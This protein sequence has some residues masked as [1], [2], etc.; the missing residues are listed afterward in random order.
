MFFGSILKEYSRYSEAADALRERKV[1]ISINGISESAQSGLIYAFTED[2]N[3]NS[4]VITYSDLEAQALYAD[5][6]FYTDNVLYFPSKE[7]VFYDI[8][9]AGHQNEYNRLETIFELSIRKEKCIVVASLEAVT[10][11]TVAK[12]VYDDNIINVELGKRFD[13]TELEKK[14]VKLGYIRE[15]MIEGKGQFSVRGGILDIYC[16]HS[17]SPIRIEFFDDETDSIREFDVLTQRSMDTV[18]SA[19]ITPCKELIFDENKRAELSEYL[20]GA[21]L[22]L[23]KKK[24][25]Y[26]D[27]IKTILS[28]KEKLDEHMHFP[29]IDKYVDFIYGQIPTIIDYFNKDSLV[30][31]LEPKR[32]HERKEG[33]EW[34]RGEL[35][36]DFTQSGILYTDEAKFWADYGTILKKIKE[37]KVIAL[38]ELA[39]SD[40]DF[41]YKLL[42]DFVT[43]TTVSFH[44]KIEYLYDDLKHWQDSGATVAILASNRARGENL[45]GILNDKGI[46]CRY[47]NGRA[48]LK[49]GE[50][51]VVK[52]NLKK[53]FEYPD[54]KLAVVSDREIFAVEKRKKVSKKNENVD[55]IKSFNDI[56]VG[57]YVVHR[58]H[59]I[60]QYVGINKM[61]VNGIIKDYFKIQY[62]GSDT[63]YVPVDQM[64]LLYKYIG[65]TDIQIKVHKLGG[66]EWSKTKARVKKSTAQLAGQL[67]KLY[68]VRE[69]TKGYAFSE[70]TAWQREFEDTFVYQETDDQLRSIE[71]VKTDMEKE[72]PMDRL[73]C[74][75]VGYGKT[76]VAIRAAFKAVMDSKQVAYLCPT[77]I[78]AMQQ[79]DNFCD[80]MKDFPI[81]VEMLSR[82]RTAAQQKKILKKLKTGEIDIIIG[83]HRILQKDLEFND[84]G[85]LIIDEEQRFGVAHKEKL[86]ELKKDVDVLTMTATPIPRTLHMSMI[87]IRDMSVLAE[88]PQNR[89]PVQTYVLEQNMQILADAMKKE[90]ARGG[91]VYYLFNRVQGI[92][93]TA[94]T[95]QALIPDARIAVGH[96]KMNETELEDIMYDMVN[97]NTDI[98]VCTTIIETGLDIPNA[99]TII[100]ENAD[101]MGLSQL[102]QLRGRV[103]RSNRTA[104]AYLTYQKN[105]TLSD[106]AQKRLRAIKEFTEF[107]S[108]FKIAM[109]DLEIRGAGNVLGAEQH[110]HMDA[111][112]YDMYCRLLQESVN[113]AKGIETKEDMTV[114]IDLDIDAYIPER[115][116]K[117]NNQRIDIYKKIAS[118]ENQDDALEIEDELV[119]RYGD[120]PRAANN[121]INIAVIKSIAKEIGIYEIIQANGNILFRFNAGSIDLQTISV[122]VQKMSGKILFSASDKPYIT[123]LARQVERKKLLGNITIILQTLNELKN[124]EK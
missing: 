119:D 65:N 19:V 75:D 7:Y 23:K 56:N 59:G 13:L 9:T 60:G 94:E 10:D 122:L 79:Y 117:N 2:L 72:R 24:S 51:I 105:K 43:K 120:I 53:G 21:V 80:R 88:P 18:K 8:E 76:E 78:L 4:L 22:K 89:Y 34:E 1:P 77:T 86:K 58:A 115:Y 99:N 98:L 114:S 106:V 61:T 118:I 87:N 27:L 49:K 14:L 37:R 121:L 68:A 101:K 40:I 85:L 54:I 67:I 74:G 91:Q 62:Q 95:I 45:A 97:G 33:L 44:G 39:H 112:G 57:D 32:I 3:C 30:F 52:G 29:S 109:R 102:Y 124:G 70:D 81:K 84:L 108:G 83:T 73:L 42:Y 15:D 71:E 103:G 46:H 48:E 64:D 36:N 35:I 55:R 12:N 28:D 96:G 113:E 107:G 69:K 47:E 38:S 92:Y 66:T 111:V 100:I 17:E 5:L 50:I 41:S 104:Y 82:F 110:G 90:L 16:P 31:M 93:R 26:S 116:I 6:R 123:Y 20:A 63:L 25:D 11:Y